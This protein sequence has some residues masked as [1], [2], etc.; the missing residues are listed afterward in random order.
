MW[1]V[2]LSV[3][4]KTWRKLGKDWRKRIHSIGTT[5]GRREWEFRILGERLSPIQVLKS[6]G[7]Q[8]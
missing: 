2:G 6:G 1:F 4:R 3:C 8:I 7:F 5:E